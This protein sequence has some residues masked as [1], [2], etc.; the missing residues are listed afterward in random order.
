ME[1]DPLTIIRC[2]IDDLA[3]IYGAMPDSNPLSDELWA[4]NRRLAEALE[5]LGLDPEADPH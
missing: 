5:A 2:C 3:E 1:T 4:I